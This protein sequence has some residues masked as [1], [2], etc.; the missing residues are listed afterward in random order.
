VP[1]KATKPTFQKKLEVKD[2]IKQF[3]E[4]PNVANILSIFNN[5]KLRQEN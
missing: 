4:E 2:E 5:K 1:K 3:D